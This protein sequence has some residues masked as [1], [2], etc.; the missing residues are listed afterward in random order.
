MRPYNFAAQNHVQVVFQMPDYSNGCCGIR[1]NADIG[2]HTS[3]VCAKLNFVR[4]RHRKWCCDTRSARRKYAIPAPQSLCRGKA[5]RL[6]DGKNI[7][8]GVRP[9]CTSNAIISLYTKVRVAVES[10]CYVK[11]LCCS[12]TTGSDEVL[13]LEIWIFT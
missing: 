4:H 13:Y 6:L 10:F 9:A 11:S 2:S 3:S 1:H 12:R 5:V 7:S 8:R